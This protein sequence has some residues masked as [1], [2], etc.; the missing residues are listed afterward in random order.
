MQK[1]IEFEDKVALNENSS[2]PEINKITDDNINE[3]K[4]IVNGSLQGTNA[5]GSIVVD[6]VKCKN[7]FSLNN[8]I[9]NTSI[10]SEG[11]IV[12][13]SLTSMYYI[14]VQYGKS[15]V[16]SFTDNSSSGNVLYGF[17]DSIPTI[18]TNCTYNVTTCPELNGMIFTPVSASN[19]YL[20]IRLRYD[21]NQV[22][23]MSNIQVEEGTTPTL[24][25]P[26]KEFENGVDDTGWVNLNS[27]RGVWYRMKNS[28]VTIRIGDYTAT[29]INAYS[30]LSLGTLPDYLKPPVSITGSVNFKNSSNAY[31]DPVT[32][33]RVMD[34][35]EVRLQ[36]W[37]A[38]NFSY[39]ASEGSIIYIV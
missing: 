19:K 36:N 22:S 13:N 12:S 18:G 9:Y 10:S 2:I 24:Y 29:T 37:T 23:N 39:N 34:T 28:V 21:A 26:H 1:I 20:C 17:S 16:M 5:M 4:S 35:G 7:L 30:N 3:I 31:L 33:F 8:Y 38:S 14:P 15:Y 32:L 11:E 6:D 27:S 25:T